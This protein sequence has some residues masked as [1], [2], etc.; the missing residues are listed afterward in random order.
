MGF[1]FCGDY[2]KCRSVHSE[3]FNNFLMKEFLETEK[4]HENTLQSE[5]TEVRFAVLLEFSAN[6]FSMSLGNATL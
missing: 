1:Q 4:A 2:D 6:M 5:S 3:G